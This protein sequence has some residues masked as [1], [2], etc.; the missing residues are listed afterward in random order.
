MNAADGVELAGYMVSAFVIGFCG[1]YLIA[2][3][4]QAVDLAV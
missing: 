3:F 1:G 2:R 4:R